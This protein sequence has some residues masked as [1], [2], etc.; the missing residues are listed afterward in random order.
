MKQMEEITKT[1]TKE[2]ET[3]K[4]KIS[5]TVYLKI[6]QYQKKKDRNTYLHA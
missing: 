2:L 1:M 5:P 4:S 6:D 3:T